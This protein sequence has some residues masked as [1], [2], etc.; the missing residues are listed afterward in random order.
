MAESSISQQ[1][2]ITDSVEKVCFPFLHTPTHDFRDRI[3]ALSYEEEQHHW[4][5]TANPGQGSTA[6][7]FCPSRSLPGNVQRFCEEGL[8]ILLPLFHFVLLEY[9]TEREM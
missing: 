3:E 8:G 6:S 4:D 7:A 2:T 9:L 5:P 1:V